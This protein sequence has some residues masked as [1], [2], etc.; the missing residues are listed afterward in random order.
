[1][2]RFTKESGHERGL[3]A[4]MELIRSFTDG[5]NEYEALDPKIRMTL[6]F[7]D[8]CHLKEKYRGFGTSPQGGKHNQNWDNQR[9]VGKVTLNSYDGSS[10][11]STR[12]WVQKLDTYITLTK[13][14][15]LMPSNL[16]RPIWKEKHKSGGP[17]NWSCLGILP[18]LL[19]TSSLTTWWSDLTRRIHNCTSGSWRTWSIL[20]AQR[21]L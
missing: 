3:D 5:I 12:A 2:P 4:F 21:P 10:K 6:P 8:Y 9:V 15:R 17:T 20:A 1:M 16:P 11:S 14:G 19:T 18:L 7:G 13:W